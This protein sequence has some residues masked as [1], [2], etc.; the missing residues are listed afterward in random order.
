M[1]AAMRKEGLG[2][3]LFRRLA[4]RILY[5][6]LEPLTPSKLRLAT[7]AAIEHHNAAI[8]GF[9]LGHTNGH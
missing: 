3:D 2:L 8:A 4:E 7:A 1:L 5:R 6:L 9:F